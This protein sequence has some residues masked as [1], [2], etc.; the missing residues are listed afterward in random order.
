VRQHEEDFKAQ[1][2]GAVWRDIDTAKRQRTEIERQQ[3][4]MLEQAGR[5][6]REEFAAAVV[7]G[8][9]Q[10]ER[11]LARLAV[12]KDAELAELR[13]LENTRRRELEDAMKRRRIVERLK[14]RQNKAFR[15]EVEREQRKFA[16]EVATNQAAIARQTHP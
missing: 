1:A 16:D 10:Y 5:V 7:Q 2:L 15:E 12:E 3:R 13:E 11:H 4:A 14:E 8:Y 6:A 9:Y